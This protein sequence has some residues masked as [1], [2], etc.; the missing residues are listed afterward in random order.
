MNGDK[1][2]GSEELLKHLSSLT[3]S[4]ETVLS[5][6]AALEPLECALSSHDVLTEELASLGMSSAVA[7]VLE[8]IERFIIEQA[9]AL[10][11]IAQSTQQQSHIVDCFARHLLAVEG[12]GPA[13]A[14]QLFEANIAFPEQLFELSPKEIADLPLP[15]ASHARVTA[16]Y[17]E[18]AANQ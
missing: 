1:T 2:L 13:T 9:L 11:E 4:L 16:L 7:E 5:G 12:I 8:R 6:N 10:Y 18:H 3:Q 14:K 15:P 17:E